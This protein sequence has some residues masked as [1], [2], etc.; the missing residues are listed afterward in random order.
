MG[1]N[2]YS[3]GEEY[4]LERKDMALLIEVEDELHNMDKAL[5]QLAGHGH[6]SGDFIKLDNVFDVI[7]QSLA[8]RFHA[9][10]NSVFP[11]CNGIC[12]IVSGLPAPAENCGPQAGDN[13][14]S[15]RAVRGLPVLSAGEYRPHLYNGF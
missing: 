12:S 9:G 5:E 7:H 15:G 11:F 6:A 10:G 1:E 8:G 14:R 4:V 13:F 3:T 2:N